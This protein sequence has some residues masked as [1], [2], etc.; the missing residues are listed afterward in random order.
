ML[1]KYAEIQ[2]VLGKYP[3]IQMVLEK[4]PRDPNGAGIMFNSNYL[5]LQKYTEYL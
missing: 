1:G 3:E 5:A 4:V 2:V